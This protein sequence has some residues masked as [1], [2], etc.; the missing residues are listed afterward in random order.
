MTDKPA[1]RE[2]ESKFQKQGFQ[3]LVIAM[4]SYAALILCVI[5]DLSQLVT[6]VC[7]GVSA[8]AQGLAF[9]SQRQEIKCRNNAR[10][11]EMRDARDA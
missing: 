9:W 3:A 2:L 6:A 11:E 8:G 1:W 10:Y 7:A 5:F 4:A